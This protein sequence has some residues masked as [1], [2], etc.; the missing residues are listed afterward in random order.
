MRRARLLRNRRSEVR[1][2]SG[3][4]GR[5]RVSWIGL[6]I[7]LDDVLDFKR[8]S[9][10]AHR[11]YMQNLRSFTLELATIEAADR[12]R[13]LEDRRADLLDGPWDLRQRSLDAWR[14]APRM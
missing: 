10:G 1:I 3:A 14:T 12:A 8:E 4:P 11:K 7:P 9:K 13:A 5:F 6:T 2:L